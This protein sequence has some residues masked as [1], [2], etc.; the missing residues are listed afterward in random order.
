MPGADVRNEAACFMHTNFDMRAE[1]SVRDAII[2][3]SVYRVKFDPTDTLLL[4]VRPASS[5]FVI[6]ER[7]HQPTVRHT[8]FAVFG[9]DPRQWPVSLL[10]GA[11]FAPFLGG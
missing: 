11:C 5:C 8:A 2:S 9:S 1:K 4:A 6:S 7:N 3:E 10:G